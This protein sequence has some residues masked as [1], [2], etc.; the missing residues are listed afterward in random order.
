MANVVK[1]KDD[2]SDVVVCKNCE[3]TIFF[4][5]EE[6]RWISDAEPN[7]GLNCPGCGKAI[8]EDGS[9]FSK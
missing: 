9:L 1:K 4:L 7:Y 8:F 3:S 6:C 5:F 2:D